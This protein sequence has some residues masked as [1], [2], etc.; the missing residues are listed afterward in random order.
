[1]ETG[2]KH[3]KLFLKDRIYYLGSNKYLRGI[4]S[5]KVEFFAVPIRDTARGN[6]LRVSRTVL[7]T[8]VRS[9]RQQEI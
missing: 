7:F 6:R 8:T 5:K 9:F 3:L 2:G 4:Q 1:M